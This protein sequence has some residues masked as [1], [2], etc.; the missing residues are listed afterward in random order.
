[1]LYPISQNLYFLSEPSSGGKSSKIDIRTV[2]APWITTSDSTHTVPTG[3]NN[4]HGLMFGN[5]DVLRILSEPLRCQWY[6]P[7]LTKK[8]KQT[9]LA[10]E[11][12]RIIR[13]T[14]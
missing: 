5:I 3:K 11:V 10:G 4:H 2:I 13:L 6:V 9:T 8:I 12:K 7:T 1:M 14:Q